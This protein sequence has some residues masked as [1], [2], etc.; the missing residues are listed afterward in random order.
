MTSK[1]PKIFSSVE[2]I[3]SALNVLT[4]YVE[5]VELNQLGTSITLNDLINNLET[6][7]SIINRIKQ[8]I[9]TPDEASTLDPLDLNT[10]LNRATELENKLETLIEVF[11]QRWVDEEL[12]ASENEAKALQGKEEMSD[13]QKMFAAFLR[14]QTETNKRVSDAL[15]SERKSPE[16][17]DILSKLTDLIETLSKNQFS[18]YQSTKLEPV[19]IPT[20]S[21]D[22][23][24]WPNFKNLFNSLV[25]NNPKLSKVQKMHYLLSYTSG[26]AKSMIENMDISDENYDAACQAL[27]DRFDDSSSIVNALMKRLI[28][29][30]PIT[31]ESAKRLSELHAT[32][33]SVLR[34]LKS[35][36]L[37]GGDHWVIYIVKEKLDPESN[38][39]WSR[40]TKGKIPTF[41]EF[42]TF[43][44]DRI[45]ELQSFS[46]SS[47]KP[48]SSTGKPSTSQPTKTSVLV[49]ATSSSNC[50]C[51]NNSHKLFQ[52]LRFKALSP[53]DRLSLVRKHRM[54]R[55]CI[56]D[57]HYTKDC[58]A[59]GCASC[60]SK[61]NSLLHDSFNVVQTTTK[62][63][64]TQQTKSTDT[65]AENPTTNTSAQEMPTNSDDKVTTKS[66][67]LST[68]NTNT[69]YNATTLASLTTPREDHPRVFLGTVVVKIL[70]TNGVEH[71]CRAVVDNCSQSNL[72]TTSLVQRLNLS[73]YNF[74]FNI[75]GVLDRRSTGKHKTHVHIAPHM[76]GNFYNMT[77]N[78]VPKVTGN[79]PN[80]NV[81]SQQ[82]PIPSHL[83]LADPNWHVQQPVDLLIG[84]GIF[85]RIE[86]DESYFL[87]PNLPK[88]KGSEFGWILMG[89]HT[90]NQGS[91]P[92]DS[93]C[94]LTTLSSIDSTLKRFWEIETIPNVV[95]PTKEQEEAEHLFSRTTTRNQD[96]RFVVHLPFKANVQRLADNKTN[97]IGQ[98]VRLE[99]KLSKNPALKEQYASVFKEYL[100]LD[101]LEKVPPEE[102]DRPSY[103]LPHHGVVKES[104]SSTKLRVV[105]NASS[106]SSSGLSLN[107][108]LMV[109]PVVQPDLVS[110]LLRFRL[111][112]VAL[113]C[114]V[115]KMYPQFLLHPPHRDYQ[116]IIWRSEPD[117]ELQHFRL[118]GVC[119]G[120]A[121]SP[122]LATRCLNQLA[123]ECSDTYPLASKTL[124]ECFYVDDCLS[125]FPSP[126][127][128]KKTQEELI[129]ITQEAGLTLAKW[130]S[131]IP[132]ILPD[133]CQL[134]GSN[135]RVSLPELKTRALGM[136]WDVGG[137]TF[138]YDFTHQMPKINTKRTTFS[139]I[140]S[141]FD[142]LGLIGPVIIVGKRILQ[143]LWRIEVEWDEPLPQRL[144]D[145]ISDFFTDLTFISSLSIPRWISTFPNPSQTKLHLFTDSSSYAYGSAIY[146]VTQDE[147]G[148]RCSRLLTSK[149]RIA[150]LHAL[151]IPRLELC[152]A[153]L[154][155]R[156]LHKVLSAISV[157]SCHCWT[158]SLIVLHQINATTEKYD[159][160]VSHRISEIQQITDK[161]SWRHVPGHLNPADVLSRGAH[162]Q[163]LMTL[164]L[165]WSGPPFIA[166]TQT[167]WP[168][169]FIDINPDQ[170]DQETTY[171]TVTASQPVPTNSFLA[172]SLEESSD[173]IELTRLIAI[174]RR[175]LTPSRDIPRITG[176]LTPNELLQAQTIVLKWDQEQNLGDVHGA[177]RNGSIS[178]SSKFAHIRQL[179]PFIDVT[180]LI[181]VGGRLQHSSEPYS[182]RFPILLNK[183][184]VAYSIARSEHFRLHHAGPQLL[185]ASLRQNYW[186]LSGRRIC[187]KVVKDC[188]RCCRVKPPLQTQLMGDLPEQRVSKPI[189]FLATG[190]DFAGPVLIRHG[191]RRSQTLVKA[192]V[193]VFVCLSTRAVHCEVVSDLTT[194]AFIACLRRFISRRS[195]PSDIYSDNATNFVGADKE[196]QRLLTHD[197]SRN[198]LI[199]ATASFRMKWHFQPPKSPHHGGL[200]EAAIKS[201]KHHFRRVVGN[202]KLTFEELCTVTAQIEA[203]LNSRPITQ[204]SEDPSDPEAL[205]PGHFLVGRPLTELPSPDLTQLPDNRLDAWQ[206]C[207]Q[208]TQHF[209][210]RWKLEYLTALQRRTKWF[211]ELPNIT[212]GDIVVVYEDNA[213]SMR[214]PLGR[215]VATHPGHD[216]RV[217]VVTIRTANSI[218]KRSVTKISKLPVEGLPPSESIEPQ[219]AQLRG[220]DDRASS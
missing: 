43:L 175:F 194:D 16:S 14:S 144:S 99:R 93:I 92:D 156:L 103:Y 127:E 118:K 55:N 185:L 104:S 148:N 124:L 94:N 134:Q 86:R 4:D 85:A 84:G 146:Y 140:A 37:T 88:L 215:I 191:Q 137:D 157:N 172:R 206:R 28:S 72:I 142:P 198:E 53:L 193:C 75:G 205:T 183:G 139:G 147:Q 202:E 47:T 217:R 111:G 210:K 54:C 192:Y 96:G 65:S 218:F 39:L 107:D 114:D 1:K 200:W 27:T 207:Q 122:F 187:R 90:P 135:E 197:D 10:A 138:K 78:I 199:A 110:I 141:L 42:N 155:A 190:I 203:I 20:F 35:L 128:A 177:I 70:D 32:T 89:E 101:F 49:N 173:F 174:S 112:A 213:P 180:G 91:S 145:L 131:N 149:S 181:R 132:N 2:A 119:F 15:L 113:S 23:A 19:Q 8:I 115:T 204:M 211:T 29:L 188:I 152:G 24:A 105:Y 63:N 219:G 117:D 69:K 170:T 109:G 79:L 80:W 126:L 12:Q 26:D 41:Q 125:S 81:N 66:P 143:D 123:I 178:R 46:Q 162:P 21:G 108:T 100:D 56:S 159:V 120:V 44:I 151:T 212:P 164:D 102:L 216:G 154:G 45:R 17:P 182:A 214:W 179:T 52:C 150:P 18:Q 33:N 57:T 71:L 166:N 153:V 165:W 161:T 171:C 22:F 61:H 58:K 30:P 36:S 184:Q 11:E 48:K 160:F 136:Q 62:T 34:S 13:I 76:G 158:D 6:A 189:P 133:S 7:Q 64:T 196:I 129:A 220:E 169:A 51:C 73:K 3:D 95:P 5:N 67:G 106:K 40:E 59:R 121:S 77:C 87:G 82:F 31:I 167:Q 38:K 116:R 68:F 97:A 163:R 60:N 176:P 50:P 83:A 130:K 201:M 209:S 9:N 25:H 74:Q 208:L 186:M 195:C 168:P 98:F